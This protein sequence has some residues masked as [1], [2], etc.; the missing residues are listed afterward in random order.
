[1]AG[2]ENNLVIAVIGTSDKTIKLPVAICSYAFRNGIQT[3][4]NPN[5]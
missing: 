2:F 1:M 5:K 4:N 3:W